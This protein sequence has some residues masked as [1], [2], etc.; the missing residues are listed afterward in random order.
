MKHGDVITISQVAAKLPG[1]MA[2]LPSMLKGLRVGNATDLSKPM[3]LGRC[4]EQATEENPNGFAILYDDT[5]LTYTQFNAWANRIAHYLVSIGIQKGDTVVVM[6]ENRPEL[7]ATVTACAKIGAV[8]AL[9]NTSQR[10]KVLV[11]SINLVKPR[12]AIV[13]E[14]LAE[15]YSEVESELVISPDQKY[16]WAD[17]DTLKDAGS[18]P[19][20]WVNLA[21]TTG[22][23]PENNLP[24]TQQVFAEDACFYIYTS[25]TT[26]M[27][28]AVVFNHGRYMKAYGNFGYSAVRLTP[29]DRM[30]ICLPF[31]H[32]TA[33]AVCWGSILAGSAA[34]VLSRKFSASRFWDE[35]NQHQATAFGYVGEL[36]RYLMDQPVRPSDRNNKVRIIVGN[37]LRPSIWRGF[38]DRFGIEKVMEFYASSEGN[39]G[40]TNVMNFDNTVGLS[41]LPYAIVRYDKENERPVRDSKGRMIKVKKGEAGLLI[42]KITPKSPFHGY[43]DPEKT[44]Q[45]I[46]ED[47]FQKGDAWFNTGDLMRDMGFKHAQF[48]DRLGDTFRW[49]GENVSTTEVERIC[50]SIESVSETVVYGVEIPNTNGRAG[51]ASMRLECDHTQFDFSM[52]L[53]ELNKELPHYAIPVFLRVSS[54]MET[55][56]TFKHKKAPL[57]E[58]GFNLAKVADPVYVCLPKADTYVQLTDELQ[59]EIEAG[60]YRY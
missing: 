43:T 37:G 11:H 38:K 21:E 15:A 12:I 7:L 17:Q 60:K 53:K 3:G 22:T 13:G 30:Y 25:G 48:V 29:S 55:T 20:G 27:P 5:A 58:D 59:A 14:E 23:Q 40:F 33:M 1:F 26:G 32:A 18:A 9:V 6:L 47:V 34:L 31:Y 16:Y 39:I 28:K 41:P 24:Q 2:G 52:F 51:M 57:K 54:G 49:K 8:S 45:C 46:F 10:G 42:G 35:I 44:K 36:C 19:E 56:G 4:V 50:D